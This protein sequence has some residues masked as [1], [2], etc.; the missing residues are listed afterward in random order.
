MNSSTLGNI[1]SN[2]ENSFEAPE[3]MDSSE[4]LSVETSMN[5]SK[6]KEFTE[7]K[8]KKYFRY[9]VITLL[10]WFYNNCEVEISCLPCH[11][12]ENIVGKSKKYLKYITLCY[13]LYTLVLTWPLSCP[14]LDFN[15]SARTVHSISAGPLKNSRDFAQGPVPTE[16]N[17]WT[18][19]W[20]VTLDLWISILNC[21]RGSTVH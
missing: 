6:W 9:S 14:A 7:K 3:E 21:L 17:F 10:M 18:T 8:I 1:K 19:Y 16:P 11:V 2:K 5:T 15:T 12:V 4:T 20:N 13:F